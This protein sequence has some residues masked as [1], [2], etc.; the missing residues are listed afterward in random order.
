MLPTPLEKLAVE[1]VEK[2]LSGEME[3]SKPLPHV[4]LLDLMQFARDASKEDYQ[5]LIGQIELARALA[6]PK[7]PSQDGVEVP[8]GLDVR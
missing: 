2:H 6:S 8:F 1:L 7:F 3:P 4:R 5:A